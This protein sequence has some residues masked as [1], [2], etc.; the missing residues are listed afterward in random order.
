MRTTTTLFLSGALLSITNGQAPDDTLLMSFED[1]GSLLHLDSIYPTGC[2]QVGTPAKPVFTSAY[3]EPNVLVTDTILPHAASTTCYAEYST[4]VDDEGNIG[5]WISFRHR[6]DMDSLGSFGWVEFRDGFGDTWY[7]V[8]D[9]NGWTFYLSELVGGGLSTDTGIVFTGSNA[10]WTE[11]AMSLD[12]ISVMGSASSDRGGGPPTMHYRFVFQ[13]DAN[14]NAH[15]GWM[16]DDVRLASR[17]CIGAVKENTGEALSVSPVPSSDR[18]TLNWGSVR[19]PAGTFDVIDA[20]GIAV[21]RGIILPS[22]NQQLDIH[23][24]VPGVYTIRALIGE[25]WASAR[26]CVRH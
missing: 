26:F 13:G 20:R 9:Y 25:R 19:K 1:P 5:R 16:I 11:V 15:D 8:G 23:D 18:I 17:V 24:L 4:T 3:S 7:R 12:C 2:W 21:H 14:A 6:M 10:E 22:T